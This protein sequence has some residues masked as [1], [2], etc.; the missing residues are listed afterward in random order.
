MEISKGETLINGDVTN[1]I[2]N[3]GNVTINGDAVNIQVKGGAVKVNGDGVIC[4]TVSNKIK[5]EPLKVKSI[6]DTITSLAPN[7]NIVKEKHTFLSVNGREYNSWG[8]YIKAQQ[9]K[10]EE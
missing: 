10:S 8:E 9:N 1:L 5:G 2:I 7:A 4:K 3:G 6:I